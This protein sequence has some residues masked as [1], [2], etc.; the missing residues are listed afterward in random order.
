MKIIPK[1]LIEGKAVDIYNILVDYI[2]SDRE[3]KDVDKYLIGTVFAL[4]H[5]IKQANVVLDLDKKIIDKNN[6][7]HAEE[8]LN[9]L[10]LIINFHD[11]GEIN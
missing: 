2:N 3:D 6:D 10:K 9:T 11:Y 4:G 5:L 7:V 1:Q 8:V